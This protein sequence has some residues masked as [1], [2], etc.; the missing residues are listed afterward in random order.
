MREE[1]SALVGCI[2]AMPRAVGFYTSG[3]RQGEQ[4]LPRI[5]SAEKRMKKKKRDDVMQTTDTR[6]EVRRRRYITPQYLPKGSEISLYGF[7][8]RDVERE[9]GAGGGTARRGQRNESKIE[10]KK[11]K[12]KA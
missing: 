7:E 3:T 2:S 9:D 10:K 4:V 8:V 1:K 12:R 6:G 5:G 11:K